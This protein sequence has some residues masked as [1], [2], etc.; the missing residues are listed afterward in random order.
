VHVRIHVLE[1]TARLAFFP[2]FHLQYEHGEVFNVHDERVPARYEA[3]ISGTGG[4]R[5]GSAVQVDC[6]AVEAL[7]NAVQVGAVCGLRCWPAGQ[8]G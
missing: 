3:L 6:G 4:C 8:M 2:A 7:D 5:D 1:R